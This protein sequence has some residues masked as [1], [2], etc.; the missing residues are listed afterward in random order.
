MN[1]IVVRTKEILMYP[2]RHLFSWNRSFSMESNVAKG[3]GWYLDLVISKKF[4]RSLVVEKEDFKHKKQFEK[5][6]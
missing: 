3:W 6:V 5:A 4:G 1:N 2:I